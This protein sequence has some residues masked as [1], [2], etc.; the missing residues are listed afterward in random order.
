[1]V[2]FLGFPLSTYLLG[3]Q[4]HSVSPEENRMDQNFKCINAPRLLRRIIFREY[5]KNRN[6]DL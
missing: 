1:M 2:V 5:K 3:I 4:C 6:I